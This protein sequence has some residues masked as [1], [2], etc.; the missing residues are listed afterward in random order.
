MAAIKTLQSLIQSLTRS[1]KKYFTRQVSL[2]SGAKDYLRLFNIIAKQ[3]DVSAIKSEFLR[4]RH[5][6]SY[7]TSGK[8][9]FSLLTKFL[10][11]L[12]QEKNTYTQVVNALLKVDLLFE[13]SL[14]EEGL[15]L[16]KKIRVKAAD[17]EFH[18]LELMAC[19]MELQHYSLFNFHTITER[20]LVQLQ[21]HIEGLLRVQKNVRQHHHLYQLMKYRRYHKGS[22]RSLQQTTELNDLVVTEM[23]LMNTAAKSSFQ[24]E[25]A[26]LL[27]QSHY[28]LTTND[29]ASALKVFYL[30]NGLFE[31]NKALWKDEPQDYIFMLEGI[32]ANL[33]TVG[34]YTE[35]IFFLEKCR[36][37]QSKAPLVQLTVAKIN[38]V[39]GLILFLDKGDYKKAKELLKENNEALFK[40]LSYLDPAQQAEVHLYT[41]LT[42]FVN[43]E[44]KNAQKALRYVLL[45]NKLFFHLPVYKTF[46]LI[47]LLVHYQL[48]D[49]D[50]ILHE[51]RSIKRTLTSEKSNHLLEKILLKFVSIHPLPAPL[52]KRE[53]LWQ[54]LQ[55]QFELMRKDRYEMQL[56]KIFDFS[57]WLQAILLKQPLASI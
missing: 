6:S 12:R 1:E 2:Q 49:H 13:K 53:A 35:L 37:F 52:K 47:R 21:M 42:F 34:K 11:Q 43:D 36:C 17:K 51:S 23:N 29:I 7:E 32:L 14:Y 46:R 31:K 5:T 27:F 19:E 41:A 48:Q 54:K 38:Y 28:F 4:A 22:T 30:L 16:I 39:Y 3:T 44:L 20:K 8:Y 33:R 55:P 10:V 24:S 26:H 56:L 9:L 40:G 50:F 45:E 18:L 57:V 25:K 15:K